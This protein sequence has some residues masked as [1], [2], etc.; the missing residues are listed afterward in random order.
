MDVTYW[1]KASLRMFYIV[2]PSEYKTENGSSVFKEALPFLALFMVLENLILYT[3]KGSFLRLN[4]SINSLSHGI[5]YESGRVLSRGLENWLY[6]YIYDNFR[7]IEL[8]WNTAITWYCVAI[9]V[10]FCYYWVHRASHEIH[11]LW[12]Q[13]QVHHSSEDFNLG[14]GLRQSIFHAWCGFVLY[15]PMAL[16]VPPKQFIMHQQFNLLYQFWTHTEVVSNLGV[17]EYVLNTPSHHRV[18]HGS[19]PIYLDKNYGGVLIIWDKLFGTFMPYVSEITYGLVYQ[20]NT[21]NPLYQQFFYN[22]I[23]YDKY[24]S[25]QDWPHKL[26]SVI[27]GP[28]WT[29]GSDWTGDE[30]NKPNNT[31]RS[32]YNPQLK[33]WRKI[34]LCL[35]FILTV[36]LFDDKVAQSNIV[37]PI[38][39]FLFVAYI[40]FSLTVIGM[41]FDKRPSAVWWEILRCLTVYVYVRYS[42]DTVFFF[43]IDTEFVYVLSACF[44]VVYSF[45]EYNLWYPYDTIYKKSIYQHV[46]S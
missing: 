22:G 24:A 6:C 38:E 7:L 23:V 32:K 20:P 35:H 14:V 19:N 39:T 46:H 25:F 26:Q 31:Q 11:I 45:N 21:M 36:K 2:T 12:A 3:K 42:G 37:H 43:N 28:S 17:L 44:W 10:D 29:P 13:H 41:F 8:Q 33:T 30:K 40:L 15:L 34:Y 27:K 18:H 4:D 16:F 5:F 9:M 1:I